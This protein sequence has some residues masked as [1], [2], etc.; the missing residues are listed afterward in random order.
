[1][2]NTFSSE[3]SYG[4]R[5]KIGLIVPPTNTVNEAEWQVMLPE[6]VT[7][8]VTRMPLHAD[9]TSE[10]G[11]QALYADIEKSVSDLAQAG[12]S[13]IAYGCT[14]GSMVQPLNQLSDFMSDIS[15][16][17]CVTT[18][19]SIVEALQAL[20]VSK[21]AIATPYHDALND[22]EVAFLKSNDIE[23]LKIAGLGIGA[24]GAQEYIQI[25]RTPAETIKNQVLSIDLADAEAILISCTDF[26]TLALIPELEKE[27]G[28]PVISSNQTTFWASLR[29][30]GIKDR[31]EKFGKL[32]KDC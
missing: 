23:T 7:L 13:V 17:P 18:A 10:H 2:V 16:T 32:L 14:A 1:M 5:A 8:H 24:G 12:L 4:R 29:A 22:H 28:K 3:T 21:I 26:P 9:T 20:N 27:L 31:F 19:A 6:G 30:A 15:G 11:K 25:A